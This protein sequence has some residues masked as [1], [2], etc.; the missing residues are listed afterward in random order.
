M[1]GYC[2]FEVPLHDL[3]RRRLVA[4][5]FAHSRFASIDALLETQVAVQAQDYAGA[6]WALGLR[7]EGVTNAQVD[8][9]LADGRLLRTH[10][11]RPTWHLVSPRTSAG[12]WR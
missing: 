3:L 2:A 9:A 8:A 11:M 4:H 10:V 1:A 7:V 5:R 6:K 12:C